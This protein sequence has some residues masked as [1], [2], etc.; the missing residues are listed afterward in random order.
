M[1]RLSQNDETEHDGEEAVELARPLQLVAD[2]VAAQRLEHRPTAAAEQGPRQQPAGRHPTVVQGPEHGEV[3]PDVDDQ[4]GD[5]GAHPLDERIVAEELRA[6]GGRASGHGPEHDG[7]GEDAEEGEPPQQ[8][9]AGEGRGCAARP[10]GRRS[11][12]GAS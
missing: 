5:P 12:A 3:G 11:P 8:P 10:T 9:K 7:Q 6:D 2:E 4:P 1:L